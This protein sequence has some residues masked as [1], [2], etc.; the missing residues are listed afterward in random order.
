M[1]TCACGV[2]VEYRA[3]RSGSASAAPGYR[4]GRGCGSKLCQYSQHRRADVALNIYCLLLWHLFLPSSYTV[5]WK[6]RVK[7]IVISSVQDNK[8][9]LTLYGVVTWNG[10]LPNWA[11]IR[12]WALDTPYSLL[13]QKFS[14]FLS[15]K[16]PCKFYCFRWK[17]GFFYKPVKTFH[18]NVGVNLHHFGNLWFASY[19]TV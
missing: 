16:P 11:D 14:N 13:H 17:G 3:P 15:C 2:R 6:E 8:A 10:T 9:I 7:A 5:R 12:C 18:A 1:L 4:T 19:S